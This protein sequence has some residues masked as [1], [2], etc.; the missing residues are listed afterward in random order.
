MSLCI[1]PLKKK[2][3]TDFINYHIL[4]TYL[5]VCEVICVL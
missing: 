1:I 2:T 4:K 5:F 3:K